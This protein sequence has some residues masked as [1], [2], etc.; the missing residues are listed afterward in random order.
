MESNVVCNPNFIYIGMPLII[1]EPNI[2]LPKAGGAPYYVMNYGD[3]IWCLSKQF[4]LSVQELSETNQ[5]SNLY[6]IYPGKELL[7]GASLFNPEKLYKQ[8]NI[9]EDDCAQLNSLWIFEVFYNGSFRWEAAGER[10]VS[11]LQKLLNHSCN[12]VRFYTVM[13]LGRIGKGNQTFLALQQA[14]TDND[15]EVVELAKLALKRYRLIP[16]WTKR[17]HV[18][19]FDNKL[20]Y[21]IS[22]ASSSKIIPKGTSVIVLRWNIPSPTGESSTVGGIDK[23]DLVQ[24]L[25]TG[26]RGYIWRGGYGGIGLL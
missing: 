20:I 19:I 6:E 11:Y 15:Q 3:T 2:S 16:K 17:I 22:T 13:A 24:I 7:V 21:D 8:W 26:E 18:T 1:P 14:L 4:S 10:G 23:F 25:Q 12:Q 9:S 5:L